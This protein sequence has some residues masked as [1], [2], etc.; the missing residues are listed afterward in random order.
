M[1]IAFNENMDFKDFRSRCVALDAVE[2]YTIEYT[3][4]FTHN[5]VPRTLEAIFTSMR[6]CDEAEYRSVFRRISRNIKS[7]FPFATIIQTI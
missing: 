3:L 6:L 4:P 7:F 5:V 1:K 2:S